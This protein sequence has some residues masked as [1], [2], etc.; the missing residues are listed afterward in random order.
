MAS[1]IPFDITGHQYN[2]S[3]VVTPNHMLNVDAYAHYSPLYLPVTY[4]I[5]YLITF[6]LST[7][8]LTHTILY[9]GKSVLDNIRN[10]KTE[11][12]DVH[13]RLMKGYPEGMFFLHIS[14]DS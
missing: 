3:R 10:V 6:A 5:A 11:E 13:A 14:Q 2:I 1:N 7:C 9:Y 4:T 8:I 12:E